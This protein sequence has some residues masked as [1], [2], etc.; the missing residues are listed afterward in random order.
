M[1]DIMVP[2]PVMTLERMNICQNAMSAPLY[3]F[4]YANIIIN[5]YIV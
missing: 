2:G 4:R 3:T 5:L 1:T